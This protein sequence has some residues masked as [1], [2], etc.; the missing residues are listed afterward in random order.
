MFLSKL[1]CEPEGLFDPITF[2]S[3]INFIYGKKDSKSDPKDSLNGIG[4]SLVLDLIDFCLMSSSNKGA[5]LRMDKAKKIMNG[6]KII[7]EFKIEGKQFIIKRDVNNPNKDI[8]FGDSGATSLYTERELK[9]VLCNLI[10]E[11]E[12][13]QGKYS[14]T[15]LRKLLPFFIKKEQ[16]KKADFVDPI[17]YLYKA[18]KTEVNIY[19]LFFLGINN[20]LAYNNFIIQE[21]LKKK[22]PLVRGVK[23]YVEETYGL[24]DFSEATNKLDGINKEISQIEENI[25]SFKL[26]SQYSDIEDSANNLT[27]KIKDLWYLNYSDKKNLEAYE[28][29][30]TISDNINPKGIERMYSELDSLL[31]GEIRKTL[32]DA[33]SF[34]KNIAES[35]KN[36][37]S[38]EIEKIKIEIETRKKE[39][40]SFEEERSKLFNFLSTKKA[41]EDL[42]D[43]FLLLSEKKR[44]IN[45]LQGKLKLYSDIVNEK[46]EIKIEE[47]NLIRDIVHFIDQ[48]QQK[49][50]SNFRSVFAEIYESAYVGSKKDSV[51]TLTYNENTDSKIEINVSF[52]SDL[53]K[54]KN[55][56]RAL[57][58]DLSVLFYA[59]K[60]NLKLPRFL[61][62][63]GIFDGM[64][65]G[66]FV[67][68]YE[69]LEKMSIEHDFQYIVT[70]NEDGELKDKK[71]FGNVEKVTSEKISDQAIVNLTPTNKLFKQT[72]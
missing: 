23:E 67:Y 4:K 5:S 71:R 8:E 54:G 63:D 20:Q 18:S 34:R 44:Q 48:I 43:A 36:F 3:G 40:A 7:L 37:L 72:F 30:L 46:A 66:H 6:H 59:I 69:Y 35:R 56:G 13:Y 21:E 52:P 2:K 55:R 65:K 25:K 50:V 49:E 15:W 53:S 24:K 61:I 47:A 62:H 19:H 64:Y 10:F 33:I 9:L 1:Y 38:V 45:E 17:L 32:N 29:S 28:T 12:S 16:P 42:S 11:N 22:N 51:F 41:I 57:V 39:I 31:S 27:K 26:A 58:Y 70:L 68:L 14:D 60:N